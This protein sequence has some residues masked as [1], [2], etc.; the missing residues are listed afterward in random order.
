MIGKSYLLGLI[1]VGLVVPS[2]TMPPSPSVPVDQRSW[3]EQ[4]L[5]SLTLREKI[6]QMMIYHMN[7]RYMQEDD[8]Q[9][10]EIVNLLK[11]DGIG[12]IHLYYGQVGMAM[13]L[14][15]EMQRRAKVPILFDGDI[16]YGMQFRFPGGTELPHFMALAA[17]GDPRYAYE[18]G[19]IAALEG[20]AVGIRWNF[21]PV[22]DVNNNPDNPIINT[23]SF[24]E[25]PEMVATYAIQFMQ[26][27]QEHG[28]LATAK[29]FPGHGDTKTDSHR[30]LAR[31]PSDSSRLWST[32]LLPFQRIIAAGV[33][34]IMVAHLASPDYQPNAETPATLSPF[35]ITDILRK[36]LGF[37]GAVI[38]DAMGMGGI[39]QNYTDR[40]ALVAAINAGCDVIIQN[41]NF[42][43]A[44]DIVYE[45]VQEGLISPARIDSAA[46]KMLQLKEKV[47]LPRQPYVLPEITRK[48][49]GSPASRALADTIATKALT[50]VKNEGPL[51]PFTGPTDTLFI[52]DLYSHA[53]DHRQTT[54][55]RELIQ[56]RS[57]VVSYSVDESDP[58]ASLTAIV[59]AIPPEA[60]VLVNAFSYPKAWKGRIF[61]TPEQTS[62]VE[63]LIERSGRVILVSFGNP[64]LLRA[65]PTV[66]AYLCAYDG[67]DLMQRAVAKALLGQ[68]A[69]TGTLPI[70]IPGLAP[71]GTG[72]RLEPQPLQIPE[73]P[74]EAGIR[75]KRALPQEVNANVSAL[76]PLLEQAVA[77]SAW[78]G[79]V[80]LAA[81]E[82]K[83][84]FHEAVGY[85]TYTR[86]QPTRRGDIFDLASLTKVVATTS[87]V[88]KLVAE[89]QIDLDERVVTYLPQFAGTRGQE[90][91]GKSQ[92]TIRH[93]LT[94]TSGLP[95]FRQYYLI[96]GDITTRLDSI[97]NT[98]LDTL[99]GLRT[100]YSDIGMITLGK[101]VEQVTG[102][103]L[104]QYVDETVFQPLGMNS[105]YFNPPA[106][107]LKRIVPTEYSALEK[108]F[109]HGHVHDE[110]AYSLGGVAG[111]AGLFSTALDL[112]I[113]SQMML[114]GGVYNSTRIFPLTV[115]QQFT[116]RAE[117][118]HGSS[119]CLGWDSPAGLASGGV[120]LSDASFGHTGFTGT[121]LWIDPE[122]QIIVVLL[123]N[124][125][126]PYRQNKEPKYYDWRQRIHSAVY[127]AL[128]FREPNPNLRWRERWQQQ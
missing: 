111:H 97:F 72:I 64:Y 82:G 89:G 77:D 48:Q 10:Q 112:G 19:K 128:G 15:N 20:T 17:T 78:P 113:F 2:C 24:G 4:T 92:V 110:N 38:T 26:G 95:P 41:H 12:G 50:L 74:L 91:P 85:H 18:A 104:D 14:L 86:R 8:P 63:Q 52:V 60:L 84:F 1:L 125:V 7:L 3:A 118:V 102:Q 76:K 28:M 16:E 88:M 103:T 37:K 59:Q 47:G 43:A 122:N 30:A 22:V 6:A 33:D 56:S 114:N 99:P 94:H 42:K 87:A 115:V 69:I 35:W 11:T 31:I 21:S 116:R 27:M 108:G 80:L 109:I 117:V 120:Y 105:T 90:L 5:S 46:L 9:W 66:S 101:V 73:P 81:K 55:T 75:L 68:E 61:L 23:R 29:H 65:F 67:G 127:E 100:V 58:V 119:R 25:D 40:Y 126:H 62:L 79:A 83:I 57:P 44:V 51:I 123:T 49:Y 71:R 39:T 107:R 32:E 70:T 34:A 53:Y 98:K 124:A 45:A 13:T 106:T 54:V 96:E 121:S 93:L 36:Q